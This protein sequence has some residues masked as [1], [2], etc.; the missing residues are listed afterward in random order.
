VVTRAL[1]LAGGFGPSRTELDATW[2]GWADGLE[3]VIAADAGALLAGPL[4]VRL[5]LIVGDADS[6]GEPGL[7]AFAGQ[8]IAI[9]RSPSDKD[10][11]DL[12]LALRAAIGRGARAI[13]VLGAFGGRVDHLLVNVSLLA[14]PGLAGREVTLL[15]GRTRVRLVDG[16]PA[17]PVRLDLT[18]RPG[19]L[20]TLLPFEGSADGVTTGGLRWPLAGATLEPGSSLG[21]SNEVLGLRPPE[22]WVEIRAGRLLVIETILLGS[23]P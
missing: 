5:D 13:V 6:L 20:V 2:P 14:L 10:E 23:E 4:G 11:S 1:V 16:T 12:E 21:L 3:L 17:G 18:H 7:A 22:A 15:D 9:D 19:A 8:G